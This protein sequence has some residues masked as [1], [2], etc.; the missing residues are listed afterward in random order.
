M[1]QR[2]TRTAMTA[3][4]ALPT[5]T[6]SAAGTRILARA[7]ALALHSE[8][9]DGLTCTFLRPAHRAAAELLRTWMAE[10]GMTA[11]VDPVGNVVG[12]YEAADPAARTLLIGSH[13]DTVR[14]GGKYD[15]RLGIL[16]GIEAVTALERERLRLPFHVEVIGFSEEEGVR[17]HTPYLGSLAVAGRFAPALLDVADEDG[18]TVADA[19]RAAGGEPA[20]VPALARDPSALAG[21]LE[22]HIEQGPALLSA[23]VPVGVVTAIAGATRHMLTI[24]GTA[25]HAG[26]V[27]MAM[28]HDAAA[29]AAE[30]VL[31]VERRCGADPRTVGTVGRLSVPNGAVNVIPGRCELSLDIRSGDD[32]A[33]DAAVADVLAVARAVA[34]R[35]GVRLDIRELVRTAAV[36]CTPRLQ[37][38]F[39]AAIGRAGLPVHR[40][41]SGA[42]HDAMVFGGLTEIGMLFVRCGNGGISHDPRESVTAADAGI[43]AAILLDTLTHLAA[44]P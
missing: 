41:P 3:A 37:E 10:A 28:R 1:H 44:A 16:A 5:D 13:Y 23:G 6:A 35:R 38:A 39:A 15:G 11:T 27:P 34:A 29:A 32:A 12:R 9:V 17:F 24:E 36:P 31:E 14:N 19:I 7:D 43:A 2:Y 25:G 30:I 40:L 26:T 8:G 18:V 4:A 33:R 42:G 21:Y 20:A 22:V